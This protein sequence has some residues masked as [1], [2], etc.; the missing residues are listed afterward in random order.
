MAEERF[1]TLSLDMR[2]GDSLA[3]GDVVVEFVHKA[4]QRARIRVSA[5]RSTAIKKMSSTSNEKSLR[6]VPDMAHSVPS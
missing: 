5:P 4:G 6:V 3:M 1:T 2:P